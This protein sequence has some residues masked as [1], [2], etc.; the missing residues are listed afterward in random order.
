MGRTRIP[1]ADSMT[2]PPYVRALLRPD[3]FPHPADDIR[4]HETHISWVVLAGP[5]AYKVKKPVNLGFLDFSTVERRAGACAEE[6]RLNRRLSPDIYLGVVQIVERA[7]EY[8]VGGPG[9]PAEPVVQMRR[10]PDAGML[11]NLLAD[12]AVD[13]RLVRRIARRVAAFHASAATGP[14]VDEHGSLAT[15]RANWDEN[16]AQ[17][18]PFVGRVLPATL[19]EMIRSYVD[20]FLTEHAGLFK[21]RV[22]EGRIREG[23][24]DLHAASICVVDGRPRFFDCLEFNPRFRCADVAAEV[25]FLAMDLT[26]FGRADLAHAFVDAYLRASGDAELARL[27]DFYACYR[28]YVRG[29][30]RCL[31]LTE[32]GLTPAEEERTRAEAR[33]YFD[34]AWSYAGGLTRPMLV[35][36]MGLPASGKSSLARA[37]AGRLGFV[38]LSSDVV[39]KQLAGLRPTER[40]GGAM[41]EGLYTP[42]ATRQTYAALRR[43]AARWLRLGRSVVLDATYGRA[44]ERAAV[45]HLATRLGVPLTIFLCRVDEATIL[46]RLAARDQNAGEISDARLEHWPA[47]RGAFSEPDEITDVVAVDSGASVERAVEEALVA[48][49]R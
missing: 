39:R 45:R 35:V 38:H 10:L 20:R 34:L 23:H 15:V 4:L 6:V 37:L 29:K 47:L 36:T 7:G 9:H 3:T 24:G 1:R 22:Q 8:F 31:R 16:F 17:M 12:G 18:A 2:L 5:Y 30:V 25:A 32:P 43:R 49:R 33:S 46:A 19:N 11:P 42:A 41:N 44:E 21:R 48:L 28:A 14:G 40:G 13:V 26:H 27:L